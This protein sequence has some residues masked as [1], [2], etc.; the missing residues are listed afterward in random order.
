MSL[1]CTQGQGA[2][3]EIKK[4][5]SNDFKF[6]TRIGSPTS[7]IKTR[8][9]HSCLYDEI[10]CSQL[11]SIHHRIIKTLNEAP[12]DVHSVYTGS[13]IYAA[14]MTLRMF[15]IIWLHFPV[16]NCT[17]QCLHKIGASM[18]DS[19][20]EVLWPCIFSCHIPPWWLDQINLLYVFLEADQRHPYEP[21]TP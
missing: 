13:R 5:W 20:N 3:E 14:L 16:Q 12:A 19:K 4:T 21:S 1:L 9:S 8:A 17:L 15:M 7:S 18:F 6:W 2:Q 11:F 10:K